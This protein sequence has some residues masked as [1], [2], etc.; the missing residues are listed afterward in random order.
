MVMKTLEYDFDKE[1]KFQYQGV[2]E[3]AFIAHFADFISKIWQAHPFREGNT[4]TTVNIKKLF[5]AYSDRSFFRRK[6]VLAVLDM[7][8]TAASDLLEKMLSR[9]IIER[10]KGHGKGACRF[11][12][13][14][15]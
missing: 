8:P 3:S 9:R 15:A 6:D 11:V 1:A 14:I 13:N 4:R 7:S 2:P 5:S 12:A 10:I